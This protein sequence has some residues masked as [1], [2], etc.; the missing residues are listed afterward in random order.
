[1]S[2]SGSRVSRCQGSD[3]K[4]DLVVV[5][6]GI[7]GAALAW[8]AVSRGLSVILLEKNDFGSGT[9]ANS[10]KMIHG[11]IRY[12]QDFDFIRMR[13]SI[14]ERR[15][16]LRIAPH[17]VAPLEC[18]MPTYR[19][20]TK[21]RLALGVGI[22]LY[23]LCAFD[24][25]AGLAR[26]QYVD[27]GQVFSH[28]ELNDRIP[29]LADRNITGGA[30]WFD[31]QA[32]NTER[33]VLSFIKSAQMQ[34]ACTLN[35]MDVREYVTRDGH[36]EGV[37]VR[38]RLTD[39]NESIQA[40][41]VVECTGPWQAEEKPWVKS[42]AGYAKAMNIIV[43][44]PV[45][46]YAVG[47]KS[48][49]ADGADEENRLLFIAPWR[50]GSIIGTWYFPGEASPDSL[51]ITEQQLK[52]CLR[53]VNSA[54]QEV[55]L[56]LE[57]VSFVHLGL[58]PTEASSGPRA[59]QLKKSYVIEHA[60]DAG[61]QQGLFRVQGVKY[62][63]ARDVAERTVDR[64]SGWMKKT[65][66]PSQ[67]ASTPLYGGDTGSLAD[68]KKEYSAYCSDET[69]TRLFRNYGANIAEIMKDRDTDP[70]ATELIPGTGDAIKAE[71]DFV[72]KN[73][74][75]HTLSDIILRR[76]DIG[77]FSRPKDETIEYCAGVMASFKGWDLS[78]KTDNINTL[79]SRY[80]DVVTV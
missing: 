43:R 65:V 2:E 29:G 59:L 71:L 3:G 80:D 17:M 1:M 70:S 66:S 16:L 28:N 34:G 18:L 24:R 77:T 11:G 5:G 44:K 38:D 27:R 4:Y 14:R 60:A 51:H 8:E 47:V 19:G 50:Q 10:L 72:L 9:S 40:R 62:T 33:L 36:V 63:T 56:S 46:E 15:A 78:V 64:I 22:T 79:L 7:Y 75:A 68:I 6:G 13:E 57:D 31:A 58:L 45:T 32:Y 42:R 39:S 25:N 53:Q 76:T 55:N 20:L 73:E 37:I 26:Q 67:T 12:I 30:C 35:Y 52:E 49:V 23:D 69:L 74:M 61:G 54:F 48:R 21:S 41:A